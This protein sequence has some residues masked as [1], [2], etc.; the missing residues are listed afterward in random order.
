MH[1]AHDLPDLLNLAQLVVR[2]AQ[3][4]V[5]YH[6]PRGA[7]LGFYQSLHLG[8]LDSPNLLRVEKVLDLGVMSD[9]AETILLQHELIRELAPIANGGPARVLPASAAHIDG[10]RR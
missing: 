6:H 1:T 8:V 7:D 2:R 4:M 5:E 3:G 10:A 9:E